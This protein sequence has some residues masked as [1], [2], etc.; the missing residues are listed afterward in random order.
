MVGVKILL[1][2]ETLGKFLAISRREKKNLSFNESWDIPGGRLELGEEPI[3]ALKREIKEEIGLS[4]DLNPKILDASNIINNE[5]LQI[6]RITYAATFQPNAS[7]E[8]NLGDEHNNLK[9]LDLKESSEF[10]PCL[11]K[12][13][14]IYVSGQ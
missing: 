6:I 8:V 14:S 3:E 2:D 7:L 4:L 13:L 9:W 10:H 12:A 11:N 1:V 5:D